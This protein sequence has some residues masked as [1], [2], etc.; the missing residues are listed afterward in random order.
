MTGRHRSY[1]RRRCAYCSI[2]LCY[3]DRG[4][5]RR[6]LNGQL[7]ANPTSPSKRLALSHRY[8]RFESHHDGEAGRSKSAKTPSSKPSNL[9]RAN[10]KIIA[11]IKELKSQLKVRKSKSRR[12]LRRRHLRN[13]K[14]TFRHLKDALNTEK[15]PRRELRLVDALKAK[16]VEAIPEEEEEKIRSPSVPS[17]ASR[18]KSSATKF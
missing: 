12:S 10:Q 4:C 13:L 1:R 8:C 7:V 3:S 17:T 14:K 16:L 6:L 18:K 15:H 11:A 9:A 5:P 2:C